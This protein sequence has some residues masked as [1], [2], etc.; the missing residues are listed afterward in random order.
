MS[1]VSP[2]G[3]TAAQTRGFRNALTWAELAQ[4]DAK[5]QRLSPLGIEAAEGIRTLDVQ[6][7][8]RTS[9]SLRLFKD[10]CL[11]RRATLG[12][13]LGVGIPGVIVHRWALNRATGE[14]GGRKRTLFRGHDVLSTPVSLD[15]HTF[16][17]RSA[18]PDTGSRR[19]WSAWIDSKPLPAAPTGPRRSPEKLSGRSRTSPN[20][21]KSYRP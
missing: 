2:V 11:R 19:R 21:S 17:V 15:R 1:L 7:G 16:N 3:K 6:L 4:R 20:S 13:Q 14:V 10:K 12:D 8:K 18:H 5:G 9:C